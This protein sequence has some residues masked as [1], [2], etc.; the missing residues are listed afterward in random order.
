MSKQHALL[1]GNLCKGMNANDNI[2]MLWKF[3]SKF[4]TSRNGN[5]STI[6]SD[7]ESNSNTLRQTQGL[8]DPKLMEYLSSLTACIHHVKNRNGQR[9]RQFG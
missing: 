2:Q 1:A 7:I 3:I 8:P 6:Q 5:D 4:I 9:R